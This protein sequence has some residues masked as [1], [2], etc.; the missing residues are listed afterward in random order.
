MPQL[1]A[2]S[3]LRLAECHPDLQGL[4]ETAITQFDF[5]VVCGH[6][7][8]M[9]QDAAFDSGKSKVRFPNGK[10]NS[11]PS[12]AVDLCPYRDGKL[13][14]DDKEAFCYLAGLIK[15]MALAVGIKIRWGGDFNRDGNLHN[16]RF[17][18]SPHFEIEA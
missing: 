16:D 10:H 8:K 2:S 13:Q 3:K 6:R 11:V 7:G 5:A 14:W 9:E 15:G 1:S 18:D 12:M 4:V 17:V